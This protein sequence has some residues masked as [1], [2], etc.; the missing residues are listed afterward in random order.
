[1]DEPS[2]NILTHVLK[3]IPKF[4]DLLKEQYKPLYDKSYYGKKATLLTRMMDNKLYANCKYT[5]VN[6]VID[7]KKVNSTH[8][9][10]IVDYM[11]HDIVMIK[12]Q[13]KNTTQIYGKSKFVLYEKMKDGVN[14]RNERVQPG[15]IDIIIHND[16]L[17]HVLELHVFDFDEEVQKEYANIMKRNRTKD[18]VV[19]TSCDITSSPKV[20]RQCPYTVYPGR[21]SYGTLAPAAGGKRSRQ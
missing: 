21:G 10:Q 3:Q 20:L 8:C 15:I 2:Y 13:S 9:A 11:L 14:N 18:K 16:T 1:M 4:N 6:I 19:F 5:N 17:Q 7:G 12:N